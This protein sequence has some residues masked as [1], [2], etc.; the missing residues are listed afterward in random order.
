MAAHGGIDS[1]TEACGPTS[2]DDE[3]KGFRLGA[4]CVD[5]RGAVHRI[6][7]FLPR[8]ILSN[9]RTETKTFLA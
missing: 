2:D 7:L 6:S 1:C 9:T 3:I 4:K 8:M 5:L